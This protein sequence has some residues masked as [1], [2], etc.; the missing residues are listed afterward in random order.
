MKARPF[1]RRDI[2][3]IDQSGFTLIEV[4]VAMA[5]FLVSV[6]GIS[7]MLLRSVQNNERSYISTQMNAVIYEQ[8]DSLMTLPYTDSNLSEA[9]HPI[10]DLT[11]RVPARIRH[12]QPAMSWTVASGDSIIEG[13]KLVI[14]TITWVENGRQK[15]RDLNLLKVRTN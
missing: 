13:S 3:T 10:V 2:R 5:F 9:A 11:N 15:R 6:A 1:N 7:H 14:A 4:L 8:V 12:F